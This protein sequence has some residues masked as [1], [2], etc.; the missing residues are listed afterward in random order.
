MSKDLSYG[1][2]LDALG[3]VSENPYIEIEVPNVIK[4]TKNNK[5]FLEVYIRTRKAEFNE[6]FR[7]SAHDPDVRKYREFFKERGFETNLD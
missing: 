5:P 7:S 6:R 2:L 4:I 3:E 1:A